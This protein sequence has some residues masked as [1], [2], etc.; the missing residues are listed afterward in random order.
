VN[1]A[2]LADPRL[3]WPL[4]ALNRLGGPLARRLS[5]EP[6]ALCAAAERRTGLSDF[7]SSRFRE[8][9]ALLSRALEDEARLTA[10]GRVSAR[11][12]LVG[13]LSTRLRALDLLRRRPEIESEPVGAPIVIL[14]MPRTGT[15]ALQRLLSRDP[16]LRS[17]PYWEALSPLP[18]DDAAAR[19]ADP[20]A[21]I[22][23][24]RRS[25]RFLH[26][27]APQLQAMHEMDAEEP[28][29]EIWLLAVDLATML[30]EATWNVP[31]FRAWY[32]RAD[33]RE[34]YAFLR[35]MLQI[36]QWYRPG[37][38]WL[39]KSPQHMEQLPLLFETFPDAL[40][41]Q[42][43]R[44]PLEVTAS[45]ASMASYGR[46]MNEAHP[47]PAAIARYWAARIETMLRRSLE[48][49]VGLPPERFVDVRFAD[50]VAD[51][52]AVV[53]RIC[54][55]AGLPPSAEADRAMRAWLAAN[56]RGKRGSHR[57]SLE[58]FGLDPADL[59]RRMG[60]GSTNQ[61]LAPWGEKLI[62]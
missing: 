11:L 2:E 15:T 47:D 40:V 28:D 17:L 8:P 42:T 59:R 4:R 43:H 32:E 41:V 12:Q 55:A 22:E 49:R 20:A 50:I 9:L 54:D 62:S 6:D 34:G 31:S 57:Y 10:L 27:A 7:G 45:F 35:R 16:R 21:R 61:L 51:P 3:P 33:L 37:E 48:G 26:W 53:R 19:D 23:Q 30:F 58:D 5:L 52:L 36:L 13:L 46:R 38:R 24:A 18:G 14:G 60:T 56:P 44:D 29:E 1:A 39:L 25:L